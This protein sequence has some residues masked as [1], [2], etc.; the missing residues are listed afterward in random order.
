MTGTAEALAASIPTWL[1]S[2][3][4]TSFTCCVP[5]SI[6]A[7]VIGSIPLD[8]VHVLIAGEASKG[9]LPEQPREGVPAIPAGAGVGQNLAGHVRQSERVVEFAVGQ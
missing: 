1:V 9:G 4:D 8:V 5:A 2:W 7:W 6:P 3:L